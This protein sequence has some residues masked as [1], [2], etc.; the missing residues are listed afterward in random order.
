MGSIKKP[1]ILIDLSKIKYPYC[2]LGQVSINIG[3]E[4]CKLN[5]L[6]FAPTFLIPKNRQS[7]FESEAVNFEYLTLKRKYIPK[8]SKKYDLWH[9][10]H[11]D[12]YYSPA[13]KKNPYILTIHDL[14][15]LIEKNNA[16]AALRLK[17]VQSKVK[18][19]SVITVISKYTEEIVLK[20]LNLANKPLRLISNGVRVIEYPN[21]KKPSYI[22]QRNFIFT[23]GT[24]A[25]KKN[26]GVLIPLMELLP[27]YS[28][29][30][31]GDKS[32][33]NAQEVLNK[34]EH[35]SA[36][37]R[38]ILPGIVS[39]E[40]KYWL[41]KNCS[42]FIFPSL[43]EGFGLPAIEAML[44]GKPVFLSNCSSLPEV[45]GREAFYWESFAPH[46]M[47]DLFLEK[48]LEYNKDRNK[49]QRLINYARQFDWKN[50]VQQ[51]INLYFE[52]L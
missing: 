41:Y 44:F 34:I 33:K 2:G 15:F 49:S 7:Y 24:I 19:A 9:A 36:R 14:N 50:V 48:M 52:V 4:I 10:I 30:I 12:S 46:Y 13:D 40:E 11:Q 16:K 21:S 51:Y 27:Q 6:P 39:E 47:R 32:K 18:R 25:P 45:G 43:L 26:F 31:A 3:Q 35:S 5:N 8:L 38:I 17:E 1:S 23:I 37:D 29:V 42:A 28:L 22:P 20:N